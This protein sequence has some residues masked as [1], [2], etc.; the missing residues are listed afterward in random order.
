MNYADFSWYRGSLDWLK[1]GTIFLTKHGSH[2]YGTSLPSSDVDIKGVAIAPAHYYLGAIDAFEQAESHD[3]FD[4]V[5]YDVRKFFKLA[6]D[7]NPNIIEIL[8]TD[9]GDWLIDTTIW[10]RIR[11]HRG[12]F[13][14]RKAQHT[15]SG[16]AISQLNRIKS[17]RA[18]LLK[19]PS[20]HPERSDYGLK[21]G[22]GTL[23]KEQLGLIESRVRKLG[24]GLGGQGWTKD[25]VEGAD[26]VVVE[27][28]LRDLNLARDLIPVILAERRY[29]AAC[30]NWDSYQKWK[31]DRNPARAEL[32]ARFGYDTKHAM[33][34][35]RLLRMAVEI[36]RD[37][38]V[39]VRRPDADELLAIRAGQWSY[40]ALIDYARLAETDLKELAQ[41][42]PLPHGPDRVR[43]NEILVELVRE[44]I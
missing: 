32:E 22:E 40:E 21:N 2:A 17:H 19:P 36:L 8:F 41:T 42:S 15:F 7:C 3:P 38:D 27:Q 37:G 25:K 24:D 34:L 44:F 29:A 31:T 13:L 5:I 1:T 18:W 23:G 30:R 10:Q 20:K 26:E 39:I 11:R 12:L 14:S 4:L 28:A 9:P 6:W 16:Y 35:V 43:L 33:H